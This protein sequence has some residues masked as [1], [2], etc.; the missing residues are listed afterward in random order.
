MEI[1]KQYERAMEIIEDTF[2]TEE[3]LRQEG[4]S[5]EI[6]EAVV[7]LTRT[8]EVEEEEY[9]RKIRENPLARAVKMADLLHNM[10]PERKIDPKNIEHVMEKR[11]GYYKHFLELYKMS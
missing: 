2:V 8:P 4:F 11:K 1:G 9:F 7:L 3:Y 10:D 6:V 5:D